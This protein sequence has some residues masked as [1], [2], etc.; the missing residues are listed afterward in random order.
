MVAQCK[1]SASFF[2]VH[3]LESYIRVDVLYRNYLCDHEWDYYLIV[4]TL[5]PNP[6]PNPNSPRPSL[7]SCFLFLVGPDD[8]LKGSSP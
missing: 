7:V 8:P 6:N 4:L 5:N 1:C 3:G 2:L